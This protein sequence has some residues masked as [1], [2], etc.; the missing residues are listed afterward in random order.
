MNNLSLNEYPEPPPD[1]AS[2]SQT[3]SQA[4]SQLATTFNRKKNHL[5]LEWLFLVSEDEDE[6]FYLMSRSQYKMTGTHNGY[7]W[8]CSVHANVDD[9]KMEISYY[10]CSSKYCIQGK[11]DR[12]GVMV[13]KSA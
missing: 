10:K 4:S 8:R 5:G 11:D 2:S 7:I 12:N 6:C 1:Q 3:C 13:M 9:Y